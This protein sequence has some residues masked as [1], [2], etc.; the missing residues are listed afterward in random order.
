[1]TTKTF[2][3]FQ[4][5]TQN[6]VQNKLCEQQSDYPDEALDVSIENSYALAASDMN[7]S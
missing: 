2:K 6:I 1:M 4:T 7:T 3:T 5:E